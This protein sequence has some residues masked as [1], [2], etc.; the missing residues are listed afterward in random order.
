MVEKTP[1]DEGPWAP[2]ACTLSTK[3]QPAR[4]ADW[5]DFFGTVVLDI[6]RVTP[7]LARME[8]RPDPA[9]AAQ[10]ADLGAREIQCCSFFTFSQTATS[11]KLTLE[12]GV[13]SEQVAVLDAL[14]ELAAAARDG[15]S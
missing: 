10:A 5:D 3:Q 8:L 4:A 12:V 1:R 9:V 13:S 7:I 11:G 6:R 14:L 15:V 2:A